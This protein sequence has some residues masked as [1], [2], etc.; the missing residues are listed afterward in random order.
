MLR[1]AFV[2]HSLN[3]TEFC[4][5]IHASRP[6]E[7]QIKMMKR[8]E[9]QS[10]SNTTENVE[11]IRELNHEDRRRTVHELADTVGISY[12]VCRRSCQEI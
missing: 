10:T 1:E 7:C 4:N 3:W 9:R 2:E 11:K 12:E 5:G 6:V 8:S